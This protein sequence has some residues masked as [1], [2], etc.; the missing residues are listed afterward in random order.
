M[1]IGAQNP[2][3]LEKPEHIGSTS[4]QRPEAKPIILI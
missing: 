3:D 2:Y 1:I 4:I